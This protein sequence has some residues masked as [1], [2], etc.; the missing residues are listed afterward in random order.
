MK[1]GPKTQDNSIEEDLAAF[2]ATEEEIAAWSKER[3]KEEEF[4]VLPENWQA[5]LCFMRLATQWRLGPMGQ[6]VG[7]D[8]PAIQPVLDLMGITPDPD[9]FDSLQILEAAALEALHE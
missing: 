1:A 3:K 6:R 9:L 5:V 4:A 2:G 8:Y 7:L